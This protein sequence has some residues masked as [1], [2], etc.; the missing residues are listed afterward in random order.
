L[1]FV[2]DIRNFIVHEG[3]RIKDNDFWFVHIA[4]ILCF[5]FYKIAAKSQEDSD[6][7]LELEINYISLLDNII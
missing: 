6:F 4:I 7:Y 1:I 5:Y 2:Y 3:K